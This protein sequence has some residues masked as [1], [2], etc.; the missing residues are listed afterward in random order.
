MQWPRVTDAGSDVH[1]SRNRTKQEEQ[2]AAT[3]CPPSCSSRSDL[4]ISLSNWAEWNF[5]CQTLYHDAYFPLWSL[6]LLSSA[7]PWG[8]WTAT[9]ALIIFCT[10]VCMHNLSFH[11]TSAPVAA[12]LLSCRPPPLSWSTKAHNGSTVYRFMGL[13]SWSKSSDCSYFHLCWQ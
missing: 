8:G 11:T 5:V 12:F 2:E 6:S 13:T 10:I 4:E 3:P 9:T 7:W 1:F